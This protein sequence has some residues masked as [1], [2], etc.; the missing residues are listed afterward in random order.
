MSTLPV[1][2][3]VREDDDAVA[4][5][6]GHLASACLQLEVMTYPKPGLVS[7]IDNGAHDDMDAALMCRS[8]AALKPYFVELG[9]AGMDGARMP[10]L[11]AIGLAAERAMMAATEG[12]NTHRGAIFGMGLLCAAAGFRAA[13]KPG[14]TLGAV[15][16]REWGDGIVE[17]PV[18]VDSHG[19]RVS[20]FFNVG[21]ARKEAAS[22]FPS[23]YACALPAVLQGESLRPRDIEA[24]RV[25]ALMS[26]IAQVDDTNL[27]YRGGADALSF[28]RAQASGF[29]ARGGVGAPDWRAAA[30]AMHHAFVARRLSPGGCADLLAMTL[31]VR[32]AG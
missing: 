23:I 31:F 12:V 30:I 14:G 5:A 9:Q 8:A 13:F 26:L 19:A 25:H 17:G 1:T 24:A 4:A 16:A 29:L 15:I 20:R 27:L 7:Q 3:S 21:G 6:I 2:T 11:R 28:A 32:H 10:E 18:T 22:G